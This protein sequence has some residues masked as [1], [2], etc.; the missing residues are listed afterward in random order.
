VGR[1]SDVGINW[2]PRVL[3]ENVEDALDPDALN[4]D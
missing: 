2:P 3:V 4:L 1:L